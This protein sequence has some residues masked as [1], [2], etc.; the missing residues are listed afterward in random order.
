[1]AAS[2]AAGGVKSLSLPP[3]VL[4]TSTNILFGD[5]RWDHGRQAG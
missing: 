1:M 2:A 5:L 3:S 4:S